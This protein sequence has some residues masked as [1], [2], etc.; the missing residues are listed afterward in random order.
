MFPGANADP[1]GADYVVVGAPLDASTTFEP[2]AR[3]GPR[4]VRHFATPFDDYDQ[5]TGSHFTDLSVAD[6][7]DVGPTDDVEE[8][9][10]F[11]E[12]T[13]GDYA[14]D[15]AVPLLV[16]GEHTVTVAGVRALDPDVFVCLDAH[17]DLYEA[18]AGNPLSHATVTRH[19]LDVADRAVILGARTGSEA[20]WDR[21]AE[22]D[23]T[24]VPPADV[25]DW[26]PDLEAA[27]ER[28][29]PSTSTPPT[30]ATRP[31]PEPRSRS[32]WNRAR[33]ATSFGPSLPTPSAST[34]SKSTT[35]TTARPQSSA[36]N[37][38]ASSSSPTRTRIRPNTLFDNATGCGRE[39]DSRRPA[40]IRGGVVV[41]P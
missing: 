31:A 28:T 37:S 36:P 32:A 26:T 34:S 27:S 19:A 23:V 5:R 9:L 21:A 29:S 33:C 13:V 14:E 11:L 6:H 1:A 18:Y 8:Y 35:A 2:G 41:H 24:V 10:H 20:E 16:G 22:A 40:R 15:D 7:G 3:F 25:A 17:L 39:R 12:G 38:S 30:R 4:R